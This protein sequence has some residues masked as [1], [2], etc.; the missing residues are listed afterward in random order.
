M[1]CIVGVTDIGT[2]AKTTMALIAA[3]ELGVPLAKV[4]SW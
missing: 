2:A 3:E 1:I 4:D